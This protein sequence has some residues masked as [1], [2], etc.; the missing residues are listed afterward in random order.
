MENKVL[1][2]VDFFFNKLLPKKFIVI[3]VA[4]IFVAKQMNIPTQYWELLKYYMI[5][6]AVITTGSNVAKAVTGKDKAE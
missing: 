2:A 6:G 1:K 5:G 4:T 3:T